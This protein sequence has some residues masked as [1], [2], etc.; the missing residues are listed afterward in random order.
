MTCLPESE[1]N[2][3]GFFYAAEKAAGTGG[4]LTGKEEPV[5]RKKRMGEKWH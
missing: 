2:C 4:I 1:I 5:E 3:S